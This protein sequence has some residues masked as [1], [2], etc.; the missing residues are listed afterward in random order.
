MT[1]MTILR[2][3]TCCLLSQ[4]P[5]AKV[6]GEPP[7]LS[8]RIYGMVVTV[9][10]AIFEDKVLHF[11]T[12]TSEGVEY[13]LSVSLPLKV[14]IIPELQEFLGG[15]D[16]I[17]VGIHGKD[18]STGQQLSRSFPQGQGTFKLTFEK[19]TVTGLGG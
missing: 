19:E 12:V 1:R 7:P 10:E 3:L 16:R 17:W 15:R 5:S 18:P 13:G 14:G 6:N 2:L 8:G 9:Q 11:K 4:S